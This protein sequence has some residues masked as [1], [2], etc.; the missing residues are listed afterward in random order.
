MEGGR[1]AALHPPPP[2]GVSRAAAG[3]L[4]VLMAAGSLTL[5]IGVPAGTLWLAGRVADST[6][7]A[8]LIGLPLTAAAM[9]VFGGFLVWL[10]GLYL[11]V[12]GVLGYYRAEEDEFGPGAAPR[13]LGGP[14]EALLV[15]SLVIAL[16]ALGVW[17][18]GFERHL[19]PTA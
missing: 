12:T 10:N 6:A 18:F 9:I 3:F 2:R 19:T 17:I 11:R 14:L 5:W 16:I 8:Y 7:E 1:Q 4:F 13:H 15:I